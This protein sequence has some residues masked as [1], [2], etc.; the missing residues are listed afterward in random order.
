[1]KTK[2]RITKLILK[3]SHIFLRCVS[4]LYLVIIFCIEAK[5]NTIKITETQIL[6]INLSNKKIDL[7]KITNV[8]KI[9]KESYC[10]SICSSVFLRICVNILITPLKR[11]LIDPPISYII[12]LNR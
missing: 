6:F 11:L 2:Y 4:S 7:V 5:I 1:M 3:C 10:L 12:V 9:R 8:A